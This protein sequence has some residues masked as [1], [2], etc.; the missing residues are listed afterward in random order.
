[1]EWILIGLIVAI[2]AGSTVV[3]DAMLNSLIPMA[4]HAE[5][6]MSTALSG[7][8][9]NFSGLFSLFFNFG[10]SLIVLKFLKRGFETYTLWQEGDPDYDPLNL[11]VNFLKA[12]V[13][14]IC[15][16]I[17]Y[18]FLIEVTEKL[19][20]QLIAQINGLLV[21]QNLVEYIINLVSNS[22]FQA[23]AGLTVVICYCILYLQFMMRGIEMLIMR[24]GIP[25]AC[26][27]LID[28]DQGMFAPY[29]KKFIMNAATVMVQIALI[30]LSLTVLLM[31]N[32]IYA[33]AICL[34]AIKTPR[35]I[36]E[37]M[38]QTGNGGSI[39]G[40]VYHTTSLVRMAAGVFKK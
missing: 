14:A 9:L 35:F 37:F 30:K 6:Y 27:G 18:D 20:D 36:Q 24:I 21:Q 10:L 4:F 22:I 29:A 2:I 11:V 34:V 16:P 8:N 23:L 38:I 15:F 31:G 19:L 33:L 13:I 39:T 25:V 7:S 32:L 1:M 17:L 5:Q 12:M 40:T 26:V 3:V 28:N